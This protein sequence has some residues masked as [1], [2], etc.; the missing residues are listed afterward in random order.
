MTPQ[1]PHEP[2]KPKASEA[3]PDEKELQQLRS[4]LLSDEQEQIASLRARVENAEHRAKDVSSVVVEAIHL[5]R[6]EDS[7]GLSEA[8]IPSVE[9]AV[10]ESVHKNAHVLADALF[11]VMGPAIRRAVAEAIRA[12][13]QSFNQALEHTFSIRGL[14]WRFEAMRTG[15][16]FAEVV[17]LHCLIYRVEHIFLIHRETGLLLQHIVAPSIAPQDADT[18]SS[19]LSAIQTAMQDFGHDAF[20][21]EKDETL[22]SFR[23]GG[24]DSWGEFGPRAVI[25]IFFRGNAPE[26]LRVRLREKLEE[27]HRRFGPLLEKFDGNAAPFASFHDELAQ[28]A[29]ARYEKEPESKAAAYVVLTAAAFLLAALLGW[30]AYTKIQD[31][32]WNRIV[33]SLRDQPG[34]VVTSFA[35]EGGRYRI[36]GLR[37]PL[38]SE[39][40]SLL[41]Q[42][43][44]DPQ[45]AELKFSPYY[46][47]DDSLVIKRTLKA[48][49]PPPSVVLSFA[50][51]TLHASG[52]SPHGWAKKMRDLAPVIPGIVAID[53][54]G[55][56]DADNVQSPRAILEQ[57]AILFEVGRADL[58][59]NQQPNLDRVT[60]A[61]DALLARRS[62]PPVYIHVEILG[63]TDSS[64]REAVN[65]QLSQQRAQ[66]I[67]Q[68]LEKA[69]IDGRVF[70]TRGVGTAEPVRLE[71]TEDARRSNRSVTFRMLFVPAPVKP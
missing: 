4:I 68:R 64:G 21:T 20:S 36:A 45:R 29:E 57:T 54:S 8:L 41:R 71:T 69:G 37:D 33:D 62:S 46:A 49:A 27:F 52:E 26:K 12:M 38:A 24:L 25:A 65:A 60:K 9:E 51:G 2:P 58:R 43:G 5:R 3:S 67:A 23:I 40:D 13:L 16:P 59:P 17:L 53:D 70:E 6:A 22:D 28:C 66:Q 7:E 48:L 19:M 18:V 32:K 44:L 42:A 55:L 10:R 39:P 15:K 1:P 14:K 63:H 30:F 34:I 47:L 50:H 31:H 11:P 56:D 35:K 61:I